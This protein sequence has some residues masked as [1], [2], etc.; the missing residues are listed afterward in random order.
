MQRDELSDAGG[1]F[2]ALDLDHHPVADAQAVRWNVFCFH[3]PRASPEAR[4]SGNGSEIAN[5]VGAIIQRVLQT[6]EGHDGADE[7]RGKAE[8]KH[9]VGDRLTSGQFGFGAVLVDMDPL[10][11]AGGFCKLVDAGL[12]DF[13]PI[14]DAYLGADG[15]F[16]L[17]KSVEYP[18][19]GLFRIA[20]D[21]HLRY[22]VRYRKLGFGY[23]HHL[24]YADAG[25]CLQEGNPA[26]LQIPGR[27]GP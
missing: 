11:V 1:V 17:F 2:A 27:P 13:E 23:R 18:H 9:P 10:L 16:D 21:F 14:A 5:A 15:R 22:P 3:N 6:L 8:G 24:R 25:S 4:A 20:S 12:G 26:R 7:H 19:G